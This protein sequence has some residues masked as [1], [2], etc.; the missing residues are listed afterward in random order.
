MISACVLPLWAERLSN[1]AMSSSF[2]LMPLTF[3]P[4]FSSLR[5]CISAFVIAILRVLCYIWDWR[6][7]LPPPVGQFLVGISTCQ[8]ENCKQ[9]ENLKSALHLL[10]PV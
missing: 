3:T 6:R 8:H 10:S 1:R 2:I 9:D 4:R 7:R 5:F